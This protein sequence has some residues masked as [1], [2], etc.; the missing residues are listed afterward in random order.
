[1]IYDN[2]GNRLGEEHAVERA[3]G[4]TMTIGGNETGLGYDVEAAFL[5]GWTKDVAFEA[6]D[7]KRAMDDRDEDRKK[8]PRCEVGD[9]DSEATGN[10]VDAILE[11]FGG[12]TNGEPN[13]QM[14][15]R[16][17]Y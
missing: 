1:M 4:D 8:L 16:W 17:R 10:P 13:R 11:L 7:A 2:A 3:Y 12:K 5:D 6:G 14:D 15:C 9:W